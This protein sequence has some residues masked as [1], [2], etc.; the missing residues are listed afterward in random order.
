MK[1]TLRDD[2]P[3]A[4][5]VDVVPELMLEWAAAVLTAFAAERLSVENSCPNC[6]FEFLCCLESFAVQSLYIRKR[7][8]GACL[9]LGHAPGAKT[10]RPPKHQA[11]GFL[12]IPLRDI[13]NPA[14]SSFAALEPCSSIEPCGSSHRASPRRLAATSWVALLMLAIS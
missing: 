4:I 9:L 14:T 13:L 12:E 7:P 6:V 1:L 2:P 3:R 10:Q 5:A 8:H 11:V